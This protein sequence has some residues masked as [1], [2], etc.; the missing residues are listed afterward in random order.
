MSRK[1]GTSK[2]SRNPSLKVAPINLAAFFLYDLKFGSVTLTIETDID[3]IKIN[4]QAAKVESVWHVVIRILF[5]FR[6]SFC[7]LYYSFLV[8]CQLTWWIKFTKSHLLLKALSANRHT[9]TR[10][11][12]CYTWTTADYLEPPLLIRVLLRQQE[13]LSVKSQRY[14]YRQA[15]SYTHLTLPTIL[16]V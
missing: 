5:V 1:I 13:A 3:S 10:K 8:C 12:N 9:H 14:R 16:R 15:V 6:F 11:N 7:L 2:L 4:R